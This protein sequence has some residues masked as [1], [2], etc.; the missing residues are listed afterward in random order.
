MNV[1]NKENLTKQQRYWLNDAKNLVTSLS[2]FYGEITLDKISQ[3]F[4]N[5][6]SLEQSLLATQTALVRQIT[7]SSINQ[8]LVFA[9][10]IIPD[11]TYK[12]FTQELDNLG[13]KP[14]GDNLLF[15]KAKFAR[16]EFIIR[17]LT[18]KDF[19]NET[20][21]DITDKIFSRSSIF[22]YKDNSELKFFDY[23]IFPS[24]TR[25]ILT[26]NKQQLKAYFMLMRLHRPIPI[27][28][29]LWPTLTA[30]VLASHG[31]PDISYLVIFTIGVVVMRTVGCIINDIADVD[32]DKHVART[33]TRPLTSG[34]LSIKNAIWLCISLTLVAFI[35]VLFLNL[36]TILLSFVALFLAI[37]YPFCKRF[38]AIPQLILGLAFNFGIF[39]AFS[40][41]QNQIPVE[42]WI[43]YIATICWTIAYDTIYALA[44]REFDLEIGIKS[45]AVLFGNKVFRY[46]LLFNFLSL[47]LLII[48]GIY[49]D[50]NS[51]FLFRCCYL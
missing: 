45:S 2:K 27:L 6:N 5:I 30:L 23:G 24:F 47:L 40:A 4:T 42:A 36:Y 25:A 49:C 29:I 37:L 41:I 13:T 17:E 35:C 44:D 26:M 46:I 19:Y 43:F 9:R 18:V 3:Q 31:L 21:R 48:L 11:S 7:L 22:E 1:I 15:D 8:T 12:H 33:N 34:Q 28:L 38:F 20:N 10:T 39:M 32:F 14:I 50:F 51:F 16:D